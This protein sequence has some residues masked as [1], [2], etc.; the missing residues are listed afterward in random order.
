MYRDLKEYT[1]LTDLQ[2]T[3]IRKKK[4]PLLEEEIQFR[5]YIQLISWKDIFSHKYI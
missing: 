2:K 1:C 3:E 4:S 5:N